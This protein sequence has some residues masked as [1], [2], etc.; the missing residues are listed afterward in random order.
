MEV[1]NITADGKI[2]YA[3][4]ILDPDVGSN[5]TTAIPSE[6]STSDAIIAEGLEVVNLAG[7]DAIE[8][9]PP[10]ET[11]PTPTEFSHATLLIDMLTPVE[12]AGFAS[13]QPSPDSL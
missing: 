2:M 6:L 10:R 3:V 7:H 12:T 4:K 13:I 8:L 5:K 11:R 9:V 1:L